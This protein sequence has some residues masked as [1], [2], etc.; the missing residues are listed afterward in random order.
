MKCRFCNTKLNNTFVDLGECPPS[1]SYLS[2]KNEFALEKKF[3]LIL[4]I[5]DRCWLLQT[6]D[7]NTPEKIF[8]HDYAYFSSTSKTFVEHAKKYFI[9][10]NNLLKF[11]NRSMVVEIASNDGYLLQN[12]SKAKIPCL[13]IEP[14]L[15]T[16]SVAMRKGIPTIVEFFNLN[17]AKKLV[18][19]GYSANL[20]IANN[21]Y[22]HVPDIN[23]FTQGLKKILKRRGIITIEFPYLLNLV[24]YNQF[25]TI[26]HE[27]YSYFS[28]TSVNKILLNFGLRLFDLEELDTHGGSLR[29]FIC[30][31]EDFR[32][33]LPI[34]DEYL[35]Q[36][37]NVGIKNIEYYQDFQSKALKVKE[38]F[39]KFLIDQKNKGKLVIGFGAA[40]KA[41]T[42]LN[43]SGVNEDLIPF[44]CDSSLSKQGKF[45]PGNHIP[46]KNPEILKKIQPDYL[47]IF[48]WNIADE[49]ILQNSFL[50][51][52]NTKFVIPLPSLKIL[53]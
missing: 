14:T 30:H 34:I 10:I 42:L 19:E 53:D 9:K 11:N 12:F 46:I 45:M 36:E 21:V 35:A 15:S 40:A 29:L 3:K 13:G 27:H 6:E 17:L 50:R 7:F 48:P 2:D 33:T 31:D 26:Y 47:I 37:A 25:D 38:D 1:N 28:L 51:E 32:K 41:N 22:A 20:V 5:C 18:D 52:F 4:L 43:F 39:L 8:T 49:I 24:K 23:N 16:A 44:I